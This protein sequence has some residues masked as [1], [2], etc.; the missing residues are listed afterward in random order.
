MPSLY[1]LLQWK[2]D[3]V[4]DERYV[5]RLCALTW[6]SGEY[7]SAGGIKTGLEEEHGLWNN[8]GVRGGV[9]GFGG[10]GAVVVVTARRGREEEEGGIESCKIYIYIFLNKNKNK[11]NNLLFSDF[12]I[13]TQTIRYHIF[14]FSLSI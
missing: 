11:S 10:R 13:E 6:T 4:S 5:R 14:P 2:F 1:I 9:A 8:W 12:D 3:A 7:W